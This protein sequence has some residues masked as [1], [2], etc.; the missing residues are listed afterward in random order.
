MQ[1]HKEN[2]LTDIE[3]YFLIN[4]ILVDYDFNIIIPYEQKVLYEQRKSVSY[5]I[6]KTLADSSSDADDTDI[7]IQN[8]N[9]ITEVAIHHF[10]TF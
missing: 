5:K 9:D 2:N 10:T 3:M 6:Q 4:K 7:P 8:P 1:D